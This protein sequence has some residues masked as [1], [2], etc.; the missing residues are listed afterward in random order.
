ML[1]AILAAGVECFA[2][3]AS[4]VGAADFYTE[5]HRAIFEAFE[6]LADNGGVLDLVTLGDALVRAGTLDVAGGYSYVES[7]ANDLPDPAHVKHYATIV[8]DVSRRRE[9]QRV[10]LELLD[11]AGRREVDAGQLAA[12]IAGTLRRLEDV[13]RQGVNFQAGILLADVK[14]ERVEWLW[15]GRIPRGKPT[16]LDGDPGQ[17]KSTIMLD[18]AARVST[19]QEMP[20]KSPG[21]SGGVVVLTAEDGLG[22]TV[23]PRLEAAGADLSR[24]VAL[25]HV[26]SS[27]GPRPVTLPDDLEYV[28]AEIAR[29]GAVLVIVDPL[30]A[31]LTGTA[32]AYRDQ[33]VRRALTPLAQ[34]AEE[35]GVAVVLIRHL[36]KSGGVNPLYRG[37]G[38]IGIIGAARSGL[39]VCGDPEVEGVWILSSTKSNLSAPPASLAYRLEAFDDVLRIRWLGTSTHT[40]TSLLGLGGDQE[41]RGAV[42]EA[43]AFLSELL[44]TGPRPAGDVKRECEAAALAWRT[45]N[46][47]KASLGITCHKAG[48]GGGWT[49]ELKVAKPRREQNLGTL[50][51]LG[52]LVGRERLLKYPPAQECQPPCDGEVGDLE[53]EG[54]DLETEV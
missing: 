28:K 15:R 41:E 17:G 8:R 39:L 2:R 36:V 3:A 49:W 34:L 45:V 22:D 44:A 30:M 14:P 40:A 23:R 7:L 19:G 21:P 10:G 43:R 29:V 24:I 6:R 32:D 53:D 5:A 38:S 20:D 27:D 26:P 16:V 47:A 50:G 46:R 13:P 11:T 4:V 48:A 52:T 18:I 12:R 9:L 35:T 1:G 31:F 42:M 54:G 37:G 33:D 25:I 51:N